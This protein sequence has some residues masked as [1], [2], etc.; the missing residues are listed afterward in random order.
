MSD[1]CLLG[2]WH[3]K[4]ATN[5]RLQLI[6]FRVETSFYTHLCNVS[7]NHA[8]CTF[9]DQ[10]A[11]LEMNSLYDQPPFHLEWRMWLGQFFPSNNQMQYHSG[12]TEAI[13]DVLHWHLVQLYYSS[14]V[15]CSQMHEKVA[16]Q[17]RCSVTYEWPEYAS[18][19][20]RTAPW[21]TT[22]V[23]ADLLGIFTSWYKKQNEIKG[24]LVQTTPFCGLSCPRGV[25]STLG[26]VVASLSATMAD[27]CLYHLFHSV[28]L[29][30]LKLMSLSITWI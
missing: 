17:S 20:T 8:M 11:L 19:E 12:S 30:K 5:S 22:C 2:K 14:P 4:F 6:E 13:K 1:S 25:D 28:G 9:V 26:S 23:E 29:N 21:W 27:H 3:H 7:W 18:K 10:Y 24:Q 15:C 16:L